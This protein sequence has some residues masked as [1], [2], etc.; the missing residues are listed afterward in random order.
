M[1]LVGTGRRRGLVAGP[2]GVEELVARAK[3][4]VRDFD[5]HPEGAAEPLVKSEP[6]F[7]VPAIVLLLVAICVGVHVVRQ[8]MTPEQNFQL[9]VLLAFIPARLGPTV[10]ELPGGLIARYTSFVTHIFVHGDWMHLAV[11]SAWLLAMGTPVARRTRPLGFIAL[12]FLCGIAGAAFY[13]L[14]NGTGTSATNGTIMVG[15]SGAISGL[16]G[17]AFRFLY[18]GLDQGPR[19]FADA[20]RYAP[21]ASLGETF[22]DRRVLTSIVA[23]SIFNVLL[24]LGAAGLT[25]AGG[26]AWEAHMGGFF[27]GLL[28]YG[29]FDRP[30]ARP[31]HDDHELYAA[32]DARA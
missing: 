15:A 25:D 30:P 26:I 27:A 20:T 12:F 1:H 14:V 16:M 9:T 23:W 24:A 29:W 18:S 10:Y 8:F 7:N 32:P 31:L 5:D 22:R 17:A 3:Y 11:N 4:S 28:V 2:A 21:L 19:E 13:A 6:I